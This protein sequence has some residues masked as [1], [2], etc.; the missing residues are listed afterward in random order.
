MTQEEIFLMRKILYKKLNM[1]S[2]QLLYSD[3]LEL[4]ASVFKALHKLG[5]AWRE[6]Q[7]LNDMNYL[8]IAYIE[9][10]RCCDI[11][12]MVID[13]TTHSLQSNA[14][15]GYDDAHTDLY[16]MKHGKPISKDT[17]KALAETKKEFRKTTKNSLQS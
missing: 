14:L 7:S 8:K 12:C 5:F 6:G 2:R 15:I 3:D 9:S 17:L 4:V 11:F 13:Y 1:N 10:I 16:I